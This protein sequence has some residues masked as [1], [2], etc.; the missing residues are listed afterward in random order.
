MDD[1]NL[2]IST[3][4]LIAY[5]MWVVAVALLIVGAWVDNRPTSSFGLVVAAA[6]ATATVRTYLSQQTRLLTAA[7]QAGRE[8][9]RSLR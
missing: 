9:V 7:Y 3:G 5:G 4:C 1:R 6:A 8:S 2:S